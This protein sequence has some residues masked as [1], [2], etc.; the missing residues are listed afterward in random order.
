MKNAQMINELINN[1]PRLAQPQVMA[2]AMAY[3][4]QAEKAALINERI[5]KRVVTVGTRTAQGSGNRANRRVHLA[6]VG[7]GYN[8]RCG[9]WFGSESQKEYGDCIC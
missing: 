3:M 5:N 6:F 1:C 7:V 8:C 2:G 9:F 4:S